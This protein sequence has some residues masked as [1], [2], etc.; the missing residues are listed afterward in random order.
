MESEPPPIPS[1]DA[2]ES[3]RQGAAQEASA[4]AEAASATLASLVPEP[5]WGS[6]DGDLEHIAQTSAEHLAALGGVWAPPPRPDDPYATSTAGA[7]N[8]TPDAEIPADAVAVLT[9]LE[10]AAAAAGAAA[11]QDAVDGE[12]AT[13]LAS[14][15][16]SRSLQA[17]R[18]RASLG[19]PALDDAA[20][21]V[22]DLPQAF[23][24]GAP[25]LVRLLDSAGY[26][27][28]VR[29]ARGAADDRAA[30]AALAEGLRAQANE[31]AER[32]GLAGT[33]ADPR[34][35]VYAVDRA[36]L[37]GASA[38]LQAELLPAWLAE[39]ATAGAAD[40]E[41]LIALATAAA[42]ASLA[43]DAPVPAFPGLG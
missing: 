35:S 7:T 26:V 20:T 3:V 19:L 41:P 22:L 21:A 33:P 28:E 37:P 30:A 38:A 27:W 36:D 42:R 25:D 43:A 9:A 23:G 8:A 14:V 12:L 2:A 18:L 29:A 24:P 17:D 6:V 39:V 5:T 1:A 16:V 32:A 31:I 15:A 13:L 4:L 40:T 10:G 11:A 34:E